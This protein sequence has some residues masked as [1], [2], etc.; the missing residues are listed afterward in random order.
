[1]RQR[2]IIRSSRKVGKAVTKRQ[3]GDEAQQRPEIREDIRRV[4]F[5]HDG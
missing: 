5:A 1:M 4:W 2:R 3:D